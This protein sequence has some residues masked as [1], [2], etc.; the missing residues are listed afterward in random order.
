ML[1]EKDGL[2]PCCFVESVTYIEAN[3]NCKLRFTHAM[4][5]AIILF[6]FFIF[7]KPLFWAP[8]CAPNRRGNPHRRADE[9][10]LS[11]LIKADCSYR[12]TD[13]L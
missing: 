10:R 4:G 11:H 5:V 9:V 8:R 12:H 13:V 2:E 3:M 6:L 1:G 7:L